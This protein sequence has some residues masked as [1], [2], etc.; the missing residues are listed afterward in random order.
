[1]GQQTY[2]LA[3]LV[4]LIVIA[5]FYYTSKKEDKSPYI[6]RM[7]SSMSS[8]EPQPVEGNEVPAAEQVVLEKSDK[9]AVINAGKNNTALRMGQTQIEEGGGLADELAL[10][11]ATGAE[12]SLLESINGESEMDSCGQDGCP[13]INTG[14]EDTIMDVFSEADTAMEGDIGMN[15]EV[16]S[17]GVFK[18]KGV[19]KPEVVV[20]KHKPVHYGGHTG[21]QPFSRQNFKTS[22]YLVDGERRVS[23]LTPKRRSLSSANLISLTPSIGLKDDMRDKSTDMKTR[24]DSFAP[25][26]NPRQMK[27]ALVAYSTAMHN[28]KNMSMSHR[29]LK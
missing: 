22:G 15:E 25:L 1:M 3:I 21:A 2:V 11:D 19:F 10:G 7:I 24:I 6:N 18:S 26:K 27:G 17:E 13:Q 29:E 4:L 20:K 28:D 8:D 14:G 23:V 5:V 9:N 12:A 16:I